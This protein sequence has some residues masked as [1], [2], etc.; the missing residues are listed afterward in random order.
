VPD[1]L[2]V[3]FDG[4]PHDI[5]MVLV[6]VVQRSPPFARGASA[7]ADG[8]RGQ[9]T[10]CPGRTGT[11]CPHRRVPSVAAL[12]G[13]LQHVFTSEGRQGSI[14]ERGLAKHNLRTGCRLHDPPLPSRQKRCLRRSARRR[15]SCHHP[16]NNGT[17]S[18]SCWL[19]RTAGLSRGAAGVGGDVVHAGDAFRRR[20]EQD[21]RSR[22]STTTKP[23]A[24]TRI[25]CLGTVLGRSRS[26]VRFL[27]A[28][29]WVLEQYRHSGC[30]E[31]EPHDRS[32]LGRPG[33]HDETG[34]GR[35]SA[36]VRRGALRGSR[37]RW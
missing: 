1:V 8:S 27:T 29:T 28:T 25:V 9:P 22:A 23:A 7:R 37:L 24:T 35:R 12:S 2:L 15:D 18:L 33:D 3:G 30:V 4:H 21:G 31:V 34:L 32:T 17:Y 14:Q 6:R 5:T 36:R 13:P 16:T 19:R 10:P 20:D 11:A 26:L